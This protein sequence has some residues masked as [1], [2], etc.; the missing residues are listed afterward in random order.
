MQEM[1]YG[2]DSGVEKIP[3]RRKWQPTPV[4]LPG[5]SHGGRSL[6]GYSPWGR[7]E[8]GK[9]EG[10]TPTHTKKGLRTRALGLRQEGML[11]FHRQSPSFNI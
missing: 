9:T 10:H 5:K 3:C 6:E 1:R 8:L 7:K 2:F 4:S 11:L